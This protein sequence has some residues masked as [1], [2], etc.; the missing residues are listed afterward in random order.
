MNT[1]RFS[2]D[3]LKYTRQLTAR[4]AYTARAFLTHQPQK[5]QFYNDR[6]KFS[7]FSKSPDYSEVPLMDLL[8]YEAISSE[9]LEALTDCFEE[10]VEADSKFSN[11]DVAYAVS[12]FL[13]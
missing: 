12:S 13:V 2:K 5:V 3:V 8:T 6:R 9:T 10:L 1:A 7:V 4:R 11:G